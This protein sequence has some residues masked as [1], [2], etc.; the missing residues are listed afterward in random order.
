MRVG[1]VEITSVQGSFFKHYFTVGVQYDYKTFMEIC[2]QLYDEYYNE[3]GFDGC[4]VVNQDETEMWLSFYT[5][6]RTQQGFGVGF[7]FI[8]SARDRDLLNSI[9]DDIDAMIV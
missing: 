3:Y 2:A 5:D 4:D 8:M 6:K 7:V 9:Q 1:Y